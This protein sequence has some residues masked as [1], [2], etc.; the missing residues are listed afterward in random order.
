MGNYNIIKSFI[1]WRFRH[2]RNRKQLEAYQQKK[3][4]KLTSQVLI[5]SPFYTQYLSQ[6][7]LQWPVIN[8][9]Q[10]MANLTDINT[11]GLDADPLMAFALDNEQQR[12][13]LHSFGDVA[14]GLSSGTSGNRGLFLTQQQ[15]RDQWLG[16]ILSRVL[17]DLS[18]QRIALF[19][20]ANNPLYE[21]IKSR[22][23][24]FHFFDLFEDFNDLLTQCQQYQPTVLVAPPSVLRLMVQHQMRIKPKKIIAVAEVLEPQDQQCIADYFQQPVHQLYQCTEGFLGHTC[25]HGTLH[26]NEDIVMVEKEWLDEQH[27]VPIITDLYRRT[28][29][30][31]RYRLDDVLKASAAPCPCGSVFQGI[32]LIEGRC[33]DM[34]RFPGSNK[35]LFPDYIRRAIIGASD[36][37]DEYQVEQHSEDRLTIRLLP[38]EPAIRWAVNDAIIRLFKIQ[39]IPVPALTFTDLKAQPLHKKK[40]RVTNL[41]RG[42]S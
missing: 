18:R 21:T 29:P 6:P 42:Q 19:L 27:F 1:G 23:F 25:N 33:D 36:Q 20:R 31:I 10:Q 26:L 3:L 34:L 24:Q 32:E 14:V 22:W 40:R 12:D 4:K 8:K 35:I 15:E 37:I 16:Y 2:F 13:Y 39:N 11:L 7:F 17:P 38:L 41:Q 30:I 9:K 5:Y 28:Q